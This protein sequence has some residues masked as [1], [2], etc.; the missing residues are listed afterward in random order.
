MSRLT[1]ETPRSGSVRTVHFLTIGQ[2]PRPD[3]VPEILGMLGDTAADIEAVEAGALNGL[4]R[5]EVQAGAP[6]DGEMPL[7]S[8]LRSGE[9]VIIGEDFVEERMAALLSRIPAGDVAAILCTGPFLGIPER[10]GL[11]KAGPVFDEALRAATPPGATVGMLIPEPR[12]EADARRRVPEGSPC[13]IGVASPYSDDGVEE[14]LAAEFREVDVVGL[15]CLGYDG[16]LEAAVARA[17]G[18]PVVLARRA[19]AEA[20][21][22]LVEAERG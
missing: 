3:V 14:R 19:L 10:P 22:R 9:E 18:K 6:R 7:V 12:Q 13:V 21:G 20:V 1:P 2:S 11:V 4:S 16:P 17:T 5:R 15:N 8:R